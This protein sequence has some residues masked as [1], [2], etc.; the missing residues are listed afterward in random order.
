MNIIVCIKRVAATDT[1]IAIGPDGKSIDP[2]GVEF[3]VNPFDELAVEEALKTKEAVGGDASVTVIAFGTSEAQKEL[4]TCLAM[5]ADKAVLLKSDGHNHD[6]HVTAEVLATYIKSIP[7]DVVFCGK[8]A[9][10]N[11]NSQ[12]PARIAALLDLACVT[13]V[14]T[15]A[16]DDNVFTAERDI[17]GGRE[18]VRCPVPAVVSTQKG[19]N[20]PRY[21]SLKGI[22]AAK[23]KP[24]EE[25]EVQIPGA[26]VSIATLSLPPARPDGRILGD[27]ADAVGALVDALQNEAKVL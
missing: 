14:K 3:V 18:I 15:L 11:D 26:G 7:H 13:E 8:Q 20:E 23:K 10:D 4:R 12:V 16:L 24:L 9:V 21:A 2:A 5:G 17:E 27:G 25:V 1:K 6:A 19:L 22:M